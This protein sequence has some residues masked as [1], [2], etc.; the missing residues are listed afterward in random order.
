V[1]QRVDLQFRGP[2]AIAAAADRQELIV[3][4]EVRA[5]ALEEPSVVGRVSQEAEVENAKAV[6]DVAVFAE[7]RRLLIGSDDARGHDLVLRP[8]DRRLRWCLCHLLREKRGGQREC[9]D[10]Q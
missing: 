4:S 7:F 3:E 10:D 5:D 8:A 1:W 6:V 9:D 2:G